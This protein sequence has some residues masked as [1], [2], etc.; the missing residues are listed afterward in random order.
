MPPWPHRRETSDI[1]YDDVGGVLT[2]FLVDAGYLDQGTWEG[3]KPEYSIEV[4]TTTGDCGDRFFV[5]SNQYSMVCLR[6]QLSPETLLIDIYRCK[7]WRS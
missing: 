2:Q 4:K 7:I 3:A 6:F 5:S 1:V